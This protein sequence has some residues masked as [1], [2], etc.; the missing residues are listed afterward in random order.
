MFFVMLTTV[1]KTVDKLCSGCLVG[2]LGP[3]LIRS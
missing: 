2:S 3:V 1:A